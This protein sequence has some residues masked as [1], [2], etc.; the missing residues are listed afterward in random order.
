MIGNHFRTALLLTVL[1]LIIMFIGQMVGGTGGMLIAL[2]FAGGMNF[3]SYWHSDKIVLKM[4][5]AREA[6]SQSAPELYGIVGELAQ[7]AGLPMPRVYIIP[8]QAP[9]AFATGRNP[10]HAVVAV[11]EGLLRYMNNREIAG[12]IAHELGHV[13]NRDILIGSIAATMAGAI[14]MIANFARFA[15]IFGGI[16]RDEG[17]GGGFFGLIAMSIIAPVAA[18]LVQMAIS[19][20]REYM[21]DATSADI[22]RDPDGLASALEKLGSYGKKIPM[23]AEPATAHMFI[24]NPLGGRRGLTHL[25][26][27]H[28]PIE[29]R[30][31]RLRGQNP[32]PENLSRPRSPSAE[33]QAKQL[34]DRLSG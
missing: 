33:G 16:S 7:K 32:S 29:Q 23:E 28:P 34:W 27:T 26:S 19:R 6:D 25:F 20:S 10:D 17:E 8:Q 14:M 2:I 22:T 3:F 15:A 12:V 1:T 4:Y 30:I 18:M 31:A 21:A 9:N 24:A 11:T 13:K 5:K